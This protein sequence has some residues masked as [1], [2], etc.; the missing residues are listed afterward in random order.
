MRPQERKGF[1]ILVLLYLDRF[2]V[3]ME[4]VLALVVTLC[5]RLL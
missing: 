3:E 2:R 4:T 1:F 5:S